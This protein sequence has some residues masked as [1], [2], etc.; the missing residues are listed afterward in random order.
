MNLSDAARMLLQFHAARPSQPLYALD[1]LGSFF[2]DTD[3]RRLDDSYRE[4]SEAGLLSKT[5]KVF[6]YF[7]EP[8][9]VYR[10]TDEGIEEAAREPVA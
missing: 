8:K 5:G 2:R 3:L 6:T 10:I 4:L 9:A 7:G 1:M